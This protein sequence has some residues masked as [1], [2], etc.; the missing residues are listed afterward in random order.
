VSLTRFMP[1][2]LRRKYFTDLHRMAEYAIIPLGLDADL[3]VLSAATVD[4]KAIEFAAVPYRPRLRVAVVVPPAGSDGATL[5][6]A[7]PVVLGAVL[8]LDYD[9]PKLHIC[10]PDLRAWAA[11]PAITKAIEQC[12]RTVWQAAQRNCEG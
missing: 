1:N 9:A 6:E 7:R 10:N 8:G 11:R 2:R 12:A 5:T 3:S 4:G